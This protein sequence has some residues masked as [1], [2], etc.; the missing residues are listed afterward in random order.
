MTSIPGRRQPPAMTFDE[1]TKAAAKQ[2]EIAAKITI[3]TYKRGRAYDE[4]E[5]TGVLLGSLLTTFRG[6]HRRRYEG[7]STHRL[8]SQPA[9]PDLRPLIRRIVNATS[10]LHVH[11]P[12]PA[13]RLE[14]CADRLNPPSKPAVATA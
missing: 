12:S 13:K 4:D 3:Q 1:V 7:Q 8:A 2:A 14:G 9:I 5:I 10:P 6:T 11:T